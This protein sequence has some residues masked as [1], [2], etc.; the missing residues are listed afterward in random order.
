MPHQHVP[1]LRQFVQRTA[2][3]DAAQ[4]RDAG[5]VAQLLKPLPLDPGDRIGG[6]MTG[7]ARI[8]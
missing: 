4:R 2:P 8:A 3:K 5:I 7:Q 6:K 1:K